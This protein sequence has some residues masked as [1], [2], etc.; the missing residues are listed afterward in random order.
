METRL[1]LRP[2]MPGTKKLVA[3]NGERLVCER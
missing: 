3:R 2:D 1:T